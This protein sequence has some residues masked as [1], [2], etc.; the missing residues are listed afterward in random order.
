MDLSHLQNQDL[1]HQVI[2]LGVSEDQ[3]S[4]GVDHDDPFS[5]QFAGS[6]PTLDHNGQPTDR[7]YATNTIRRP[8][9]Y[10]SP[11]PPIPRVSPCAAPSPLSN[12][13][14]GDRG[15]GDNVR[16]FRADTVQP[17]GSE[18]AL[19]TRQERFVQKIMAQHTK[20]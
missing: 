15:Y 12:D 5:D 14:S 4:P 1:E 11:N 17:D 16:V 2:D 19:T 10:Q 8:R 6:T 7:R 9:S 3:Q 20:K 13:A 18:A